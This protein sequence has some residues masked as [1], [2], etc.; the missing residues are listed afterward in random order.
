MSLPKSE[1]VVLVN[2]IGRRRCCGHVDWRRYSHCHCYWCRAAASAAAATSYQAKIIAVRNAAECKEVVVSA[3]CLFR[4]RCDGIA[5]TGSWKWKLWHLAWM[6]Y[7]VCNPWCNV[8]GRRWA[9]WRMRMD[10][11][12]PNRGV[13]FYLKFFPPNRVSIFS[14]LNFFPPNRGVHFYLNFFPPNRGVDFY[15][16]FLPAKSRSRFLF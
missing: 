11:F 15:F 3:L 14:I 9:G 7:V 12:P 2:S 10:F 4:F 5:R 6:L 16:E 13:D 1:W 8:H